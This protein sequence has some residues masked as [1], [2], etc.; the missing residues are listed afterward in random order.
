[1]FT[2]NNYIC[3]I[4]HISSLIVDTDGN[5]IGSSEFRYANAAYELALNGYN[6]TD[7]SHF[8]TMMEAFYQDILR[9]GKLAENM[10]LSY[11]LLLWTA[12]NRYYSVESGTL[13]SQKGGQRFQMTGAIQQVFN[14]QLQLLRMIGPEG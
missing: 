8:K 4:L 5:W 10:T 3:T 6:I 14:K 11:N 1:M 13:G 12:Y 9:I 2:I 7:N